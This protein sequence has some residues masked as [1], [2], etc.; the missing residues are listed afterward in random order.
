MSYAKRRNDYNTGTQLNLANFDSLYG[1]IYFDL[2]N[3]AEKV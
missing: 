2:T 3:Q 1:M